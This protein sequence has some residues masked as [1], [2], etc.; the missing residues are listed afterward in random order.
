M[1]GLVS[2]TSDFNM[3]DSVGVHAQKVMYYMTYYLFKK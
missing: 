2:K 1:D 3:R